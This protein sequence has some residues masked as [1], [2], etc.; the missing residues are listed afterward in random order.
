LNH[1]Y[2]IKRALITDLKNYANRR[3]PLR[4]RRIS[5]KHIIIIVI[6]I[7]ITHEQIWAVQ[8]TTGTGSR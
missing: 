3:P 7:V 4:L 2:S 6:I 5:T 1:T 8:L